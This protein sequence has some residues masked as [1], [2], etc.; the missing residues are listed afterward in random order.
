[1]TRPA[2]SVAVIQMSSASAL[3]P[4]LEALRRQTLSD[5]EIVVTHDP[6]IHA[7]PF[8]DFPEVRFVANTNQRSTLELASAAIRN[9]RGRKV[10]LTKDC[11]T[12]EP[13]W[14][15]RMTEALDGPAS[16]VGGAIDVDPDASA[17]EWAFWIVDLHPFASPLPDDV[18]P[19][20][21]VFNAGYRRDDLDAIEDVWREH[22][23]ESAVHDALVARR[24]P[25]RFVS[26]ARV[27]VHKD[28]TLA[29]ALAERYT[30]GKTFAA[31]RLESASSRQRLLWR[32][33]APAIPALTLSRILRR[34]VATPKIARRMIRGAG[35]LSA[36]L[37]ARAMGEWIGYLEDR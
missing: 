21:S 19:A 27:L 1:M 3:R 32:L 11:C 28:V 25:L 4:C 17:L 30:L 35:P 8:D 20:I 2:A 6:T 33:G 9:T 37:V 16:A 23:Q 5:L 34:S 18:A 24:G 14:A 13:D 22:F 15:Y 29:S 26:A 31:K 12:P 7:A 36:V 10:L